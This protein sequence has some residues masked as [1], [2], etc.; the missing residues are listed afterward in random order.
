M[1]IQDILSISILGIGLSL[2]ME[3]I[4]AKLGTSSIG[5]KVAVVTLSVLIGAVYFFFRET[6]IFAN[7]IGVLAISSTVY[8]LIVK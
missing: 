5:S 3:F 8:A 2:V 6:N 1:Q 4:K 7:I